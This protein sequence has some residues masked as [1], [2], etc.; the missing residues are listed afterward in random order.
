LWVK[1]RGDKEGLE[2]KNETSFSPISLSLNKVFAMIITK[3][4]VLE[5]M[6]SLPEQFSLDELVE[7]LTAMEQSEPDSLDDMPAAAI[8]TMETGKISSLRKRIQTPMTNEA[9]KQQL[10][11]LHDEWQR[12]I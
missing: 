12:D 5:T 6:Q 11:T 8:P 3:E 7:H 4:Q 1:Q 2:L 10:E 9:I